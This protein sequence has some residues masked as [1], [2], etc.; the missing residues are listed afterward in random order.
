[1]RAKARLGAAALPEEVQAH[2]PPPL[3]KGQIRELERRVRDFEDRTRYFL[4][5]VLTE[6]HALY[7]NVSEDTFG[8]GEPTVATLFKRREAAQAI[9]NL[10]KSRVQVAACRVTRRGRLVL[11]SVPTLRPLWPRKRRHG[12]RHRP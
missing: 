10:L 1:M 6:R 2:E 5:S 3:T 4:A 12:H 7:Y 8:M 11:S 9:Q